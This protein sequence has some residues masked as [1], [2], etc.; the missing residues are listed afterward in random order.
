MNEGD[1]L[2]CTICTPYSILQHLDLGVAVVAVAQ[3]HKPH[4]PVLDRVERLL[5]VAPGG[6]LQRLGTQLNCL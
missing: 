3:I 4:Y 6:L 1:L 2:Y 5:L